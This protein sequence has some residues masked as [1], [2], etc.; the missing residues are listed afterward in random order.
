MRGYS[1]AKFNA[2]GSDKG[3]LP[4]TCKLRHEVERVSG[5]RRISHVIIAF[6]FVVVVVVVV[7]TRLLCHTTKQVRHAQIR[8]SVRSP[9][10]SRI[11][12]KLER[13]RQKHWEGTQ[14]SGGLETYLSNSISVTFFLQNSYFDVLLKNRFGLFYCF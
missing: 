7:V 3:L 10:Q 1:S 14:Y 13:Y 6:F 11:P 5:E 9:F 8:P 2:P 12:N 4:N